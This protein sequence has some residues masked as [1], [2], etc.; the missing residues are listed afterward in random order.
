[1]KQRKSKRLLVAA[2]VVPL[3]TATSASAAQSNCV[4]YIGNHGYRVGPKVK[5]ACSNGRI[6]PG[7]PNPYC[8]YDLVA[9][10]VKNGDAYEAC[11]RA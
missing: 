2:G 3:L 1:M 10:G 4:N 8:E 11:V 6:A 5:A 9:A 7:Q